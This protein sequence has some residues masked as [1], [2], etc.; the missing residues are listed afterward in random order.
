MFGF[1]PKGHYSAPFLLES[2]VSLYDFLKMNCY[3]FFG[4]G[5]GWARDGKGHCIRE[6][7]FQTYFTVFLSCEK[8]APFVIDPT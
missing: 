3:S 7:L 5:G 8:V 2:M 1:A 6:L 4:G